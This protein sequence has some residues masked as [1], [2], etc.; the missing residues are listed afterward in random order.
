M[1][2]IQKPTREH[3]D[4]SLPQGNGDFSS[5]FSTLSIFPFSPSIAESPEMSNPKLKER[6]TKD[7]TKSAR[8]TPLLPKKNHMQGQKSHPKARLHPDTRAISPAKPPH[9]SNFLHPVDHPT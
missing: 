3:C 6:K 9:P 8:I 1:K 2:E 5:L 7:S 4:R